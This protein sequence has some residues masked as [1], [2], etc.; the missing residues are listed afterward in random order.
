MHT[1]F[2]EHDVWLV[3][4]TV[5]AAWVYCLLANLER[6]IKVPPNAD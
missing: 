5:Y 4:A 1:V 3:E 6:A 2:R